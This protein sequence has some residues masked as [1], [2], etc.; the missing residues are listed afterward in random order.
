MAAFK[1]VL[2]Q[3]DAAAIRAYLIQRANE[4]KTATGK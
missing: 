1:S 2:D 4:D 3:E